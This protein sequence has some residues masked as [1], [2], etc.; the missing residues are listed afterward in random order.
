[1]NVGR[2]APSA[3]FTAIVV[4]LLVA[5]GLVYAAELVTR[6]PQTSV[7]VSTAPAQPDDSANWEAALY[8]IQAQNASTSL[9]APNPQTVQ[10]M[11]AAAQSSNVTDTVGKTILINLSNAKSQGLGDDTPTQDQ[12]ISAAAAQI[13]ATKPS[14]YTTA[15]LNIVDD[16]DAS[17][18]AYG[19]AVIQVLDN[20]ATASEQ[21]T[22]L[23]IDTATNKNDATALQALVPIGAAYRAITLQLLAL[24]VPKTLSPF[25]LSMVNSYATIAAAYPDM[26][27][28]LTDPLR[29]I[30]GIQTYEAQLDLLAKVFTNIA[31]DF[32]KDG[33]LFNKGEPG[34]AWSAVFLPQ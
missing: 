7:A 18:K 22:L 15:D 21:A 26:Q 6:P 20:N 5:G 28:T 13:A 34:A 31:Q 25:H 17:L 12:I 27:A 14:L 11:L 3:Q 29:G 30:V 23:A 8:A 2:Y 24:P 4:S 32:S 19:N 9:S 33:I 10:Q 16:S 1:M